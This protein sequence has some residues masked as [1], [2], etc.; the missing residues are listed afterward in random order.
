MSNQDAASLPS[1]V[2]TCTASFEAKGMSAG[3]LPPGKLTVANTGGTIGV[4]TSQALS[5]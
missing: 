2:F 1:S 4:D 5:S 3:A